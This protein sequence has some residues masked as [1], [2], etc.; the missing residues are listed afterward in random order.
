MADGSEEAGDD[1]VV[2]RTNFSNARTRL[3]A[4][5]HGSNPHDHTPYELDFVL[6]VAI[7]NGELSQT[8]HALDAIHATGTSKGNGVVASGMNGL[9]GWSNAPPR[10]PQSLGP[11]VSPNLD[12]GVLGIGLIGVAGIGRDRGRLETIGIG[13]KGIGG[14]SSAGVDALGG[15]GLVGDPAGPGVSAKGGS[16]LS[17]PSVTGGAGVSAEGGDS[18]A[19][20]GPGV[21]AVGGM[22]GGPGG[23]GVLGH[24]GPGVFATGLN[25]APGVHGIGT[26]RGPNV[27]SGPGV[28][29]ESDHEQ[30]GVFQSRTKAQLWLMPLNKKDPWQLQ[31]DAKA[32]ELLVLQTTGERGTTITSLWFCTVGGPA[33]QS[34][35][36]QIA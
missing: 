32:G 27:T 6:E 30:G 21:S 12:A 26:T 31:R 22:G 35:W 34:D 33:S 10:A 13:V 15:S 18:F 4:T 36:K 24:G 5:E 3:I 9:V 23:P 29:G 2:G 16:S 17:D 20:G 25:G 11:G 8:G 14:V 7:E 28:T 19:E 1:A